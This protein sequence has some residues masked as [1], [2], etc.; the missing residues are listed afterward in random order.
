[1]VAFT[2]IKGVGM[3]CLEFCIVEELGRQGGV[4]SSNELAVLQSQVGCRLGWAEGTPMIGVCQTLQ[5]H[6]ILLSKRKVKMPHHTGAL[7]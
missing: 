4:G 5:I 6:E 1:M 2:V 7:G 3:S